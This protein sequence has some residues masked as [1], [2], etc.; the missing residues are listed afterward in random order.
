MSG[1]MFVGSREARLIPEGW[2]HP[3]DEQG[4]YIPEIPTHDVAQDGL[5]IYCMAGVYGERPDDD[6]EI[7]AYEAVSEGTPISPA[8]PNTPQGRLDLVR[9][10]AE[11]LTTFG[12]HKADAEAWAA[13]LFGDAAIGLDGTV[14]AEG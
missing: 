9:Y 2:Q 8:F 1:I 14:V 4:R 7:V 11:H 3:K 5:L 13:I 12:S 10:C 6:A